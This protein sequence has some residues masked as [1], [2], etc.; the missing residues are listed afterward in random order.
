M[1]DA[2]EGR[3]LQRDPIGFAAGVRNL[4]VYVGNAPTNATDPTGRA[5]AR[6]TLTPLTVWKKESKTKEFTVRMGSCCYKIELSYD[7][8]KRFVEREN[9]T[10]MQWR[11]LRYTGY[12]LGKKA[13]CTGEE[14]GELSGPN[15][16]RVWYPPFATAGEASVP[17]AEPPP[18][19]AFGE[20]APAG[21]EAP[22]GAY[23]P[24]M[25]GD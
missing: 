17:P 1:F 13:A 6:G 8:E 11:N 7:Y 10:F 9:R 3:F 16:W 15:T 20:A 25:I 21:T 23:A 24:Q 2:T 4:Y 5:E 14:V 12:R 19:P 18:A 22:G